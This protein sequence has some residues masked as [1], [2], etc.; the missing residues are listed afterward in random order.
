MIYNNLNILCK[1]GCGK[2]IKQGN[3]YING[4]NKTK[5]NYKHGG[6]GT[7]LY[8]TWHGIKLRCLNKNNKSFKDYGGRGITICDEWLEFIPFRDWALSNGYQE[9]LQIDRIN[10]NGNYSPEN[11]RWATSQINNQNSR[12]TKITIQIATNTRVLYATGNYTQKELAVKC[13]ISQPAVSAILSNKRW[14]K[15]N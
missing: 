1:C 14:I 6:K 4:H 9:D 7:K 12:Q 10:N 8:N 15:N 5:A 2:N 3:I 13:N 11:C